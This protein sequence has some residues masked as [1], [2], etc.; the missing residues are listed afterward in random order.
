M[1]QVV[2]IPEGSGLSRAHIDLMTKQVNE[3][4]ASR[5]IT[6]VK[7]TIGAVGV[8]DCDFNFATAAGH[9]AQN[10]DL[11]AIVPAKARVLDVVVFTKTAFATATSLTVAAGNASGGTQFFTGVDHIAANTITAP[12][13]GASYLTAPSASATHVW[14][15][16]DP[17]SGTTWAA[18]TEGELEVYVSYI[19]ISGL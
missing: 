2:T 18:I 15:S 13:T 7:K 14:V 9:A 11:G 10:I 6:T 5:A 16:G 4:F 1:T 8:A 17:D 19:D 3:G 12:A